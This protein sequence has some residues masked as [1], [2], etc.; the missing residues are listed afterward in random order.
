MKA[1]ERFSAVLIIIIISFLTIEIYPVFA[2]ELD[3]W[4]ANKPETVYLTQLALADSMRFLNEFEYSFM[5]VLSKKEREEYSQIASQYDRK[6]YIRDYIKRNNENPLL[7]VNYWL[8]EYIG[9]YEYAR[10]EFSREEPPYFDIRGEYYIKYGKPDRK[11]EDKG[12]YKKNW[13]VEKMKTF[14]IQLSQ[15]KM[16]ETNFKIKQNESWSYYDD[17][18]YFI[19][20]FAKDGKKW[21]QIDRLDEILVDRRPTKV[22][23]YW[24]ELVKERE[25][26]IGHY[27][28]LSSEIHFMQEVLE[29]QLDGTNDMIVDLPY[30]VSLKEL[31]FQPDKLDNPIYDLKMR[32]DIVDRNSL[33]SAKTNI[34]TRFS[35]LSKLDLFYNLSQFKN[36]DGKTLVELQLLTSINDM[37]RQRQIVQEPDT[38]KVEFQ[39]LLRN[40]NF[41]QLFRVPLITSFDYQKAMEAGLPNA[42]SAATFPVNPLNG[43]LTMMVKDPESKR[44][45][46]K[47]VPLSIRDFSGDYLMISDI[48]L[49]I[50]PQNELQRELLPITQ[51]GEFELTPYPYKEVI[52]LM[53]I[54][55]FFEIYNIQSSGIVSEYDIDISVTRI[56]LSMFER[57]KKLI[58]NTEN[59]T[60]KLNRTRQVD[61]NDSSELIEFDISSLK[62][63]KYILEVVI[64]DKHNKNNT[65]SS[66]K[67]LKIVNF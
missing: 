18:N 67:I 66:S 46:Y 63:G 54:T 59:Y 56:E 32:A 57:L 48:Q 20:H 24:M 17:T 39:F 35:D 5:L 38:V 1:K 27:S 42:I 40:Q 3:W 51:V 47:K 50:Q 12:G 65:A 9:R 19:I 29:Q 6:F 62:K 49:Y 25:D 22:G 26:L 37:L 44:M 36:P 64:K 43:D 58:R 52:S 61:G 33:I 13:Y 11:F 16:M 23:M 21:E 41:D 60:T 31:N 15:V 14:E 4:E 53:P 55:C 8:I 45:G 7:P 10:R 30:N 34:A 28:L 2:Q